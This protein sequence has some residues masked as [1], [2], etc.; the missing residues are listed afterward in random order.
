MPR[1]GGNTASKTGKV[2]SVT[3]G[4]VWLVGSK[5]ISDGTRPRS[6][7]RPQYALLGSALDGEGPTVGFIQRSTALAWEQHSHAG[8]GSATFSQGF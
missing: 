5:I 7:G 3:Q 6:R 1:C 8:E 2:V 4:W